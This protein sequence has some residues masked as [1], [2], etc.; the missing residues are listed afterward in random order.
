MDRAGQRGNLEANMPG[1]DDDTDA[2]QTTQATFGPTFRNGPTMANPSAV[3][4][5]TG[6]RLGKEDRFEIIEKIGAGGMGQVFRAVDRHLDRIVAIKLILQNVGRSVDH[7]VAILHREAKVTAKL[8]HENIV[9]IFDM[10]VYHGMPFIVMELL[11]GQ[12]LNMMI[13]RSRMTPLRAVQIM[14]Q[15][16][17][18]LSHAHANGIVHCDLKLSN[19]F[20]L[21]DG[22]AKILDF[23]ISRF[24]RPLV[25]SV[26]LNEAPPTI[27]G[28][29]GTPVFM[30]PEL[31]RGEPQDARTDIWAAGVML[32]Q[33]LTGRLP[34]TVLELQHKFLMKERGRTL[35]PSV[36]LLMPALAEEADRLVATA[37]NEDPQGR[38]QTAREM[39]E[40]LTELE[41]VIVS[42]SSDAQV[43]FSPPQ[44]E[45]RSLTVLACHL[46]GL[47][48]LDIDEI[49]SADQCFYQAAVDAVK[50]AGG[51]IGTPIGGKFFA[52]FGYPAVKEN[53]AQRGVWAA[54]QIVQ[55]MR[56]YGRQ[57]ATCLD[58]R[59]AVHSGIVGLPDQPG[60]EKGIPTMQGNVPNIAV[61]LAEAAPVGSVVMSEATFELT[62]GLFHTQVQASHA[63]REPD[64]N[65]SP[66]YLVLGEVESSSR[67][68]K[69]FSAYLTPFVGRDTE[70]AFLDRLWHD[71]KEGGGQIVVVSGEAGIG[72]SRLVQILK[73]K[74]IKEGNIQ[75]TC[76][77]WSHFKNSALHPLIELIL[78]SMD[79]RREDT[80]EAKVQK[81]E[82]NLNS[83]GFAL[84]ETVPLFGA[85]LS[86]PCEPKYAPL[87]LPPEQQKVKT[88]EALVSMLLRIALNRPALFVIEDMPWVDHSTIECLNELI[89][90]LPSSRI[91]VVLTGR[92]EFRPPWSTC[93]HL[94]KITLER[95]SSA[96]V[97]SIIEQASKE[98]G[99]PPQM[100][101]RIAATSDGV[102]LFVEELTHMVVESWHPIET[103]QV[104]QL[105]VPGTLRD[106]LLTKLD[107]LRGVGKE[108]AQVGSI[109]GR[110]FHYELIRHVSPFDE[111]SLQDGLEM[112][113]DA[114]VLH[115]NGRPPESNYVFKHALI[116]QAAYQSLAKSE[117]Q[118]HHRRAAEVL[119]EVFK[120]IAEFQP[121][122]LAHHHTEAGHPQEAI[123]FWEKAGQ[124]ATQRS[125]LVEAIDHY[126]RAREA[127]KTLPEDLDRDKKELALLLAL[128]AP[129]MSV[130]GYANPEVEKTYARAR[131]LAHVAGA[132][133][134]IFP[135]MQGL[136]QYYFVRGMLP[137]SRE[138]GNQLLEI[139]DHCANPTFLLLAHRSIAS[140]AFL[141]GDFETCRAHAQAGLG[142]YDVREH[143]LLAMR[144]GQDP[145][146]AHGV[147]LAWALWM[148]GYPDQSLTR[149]SE[150][151]ELAKRLNHPMTVAYA[152]CFA[153]LIRNHRGDHADAHELSQTA[154]DITVPNKFALWTAWS[155]MQRGWAM[156]GMKDYEQ[157]IP[158]MKEG[159]EGWKNT[160][161]RVGFTFFPVTLAEMYLHAGQYSEAARLLEDAAPMVGKNDEHFYEPELFRLKGECC[162]SG[163][164]ERDGGAADAS[165]HFARGIEVAR[166]LSAKSWEL[167]LAASRSRLLGI[168]GKTAE[169][170]DALRVTYGW[171]TEG[172]ETADLR[173]ARHQIDVFRGLGETPPD[174]GQCWR[175]N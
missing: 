144:T 98:K 38:F 137:A 112:L 169:A 91:L 116:Q 130:H 56:Q 15:I 139:A 140:S 108:V 105:A 85:L 41:R 136:W 157:G 33:M 119:S 117:R 80:P 111:L 32:Y 30:A 77:C 75:L 52:C 165:A 141:Q 12:S 125:A 34:Y 72:K 44:V 14:T 138:L 109:L 4:P 90:F 155:K 8:N 68:E 94:H 57:D 120:E 60:A 167:R 163:A 166:A 118:R 160:G 20:I 24:Q 92:P 115:S 71:A 18:G 97:L 37:L 162:L 83:L 48:S 113:T 114:G 161:A 59:I 95:L 110:D 143:G 132:Q 25:T 55:A 5:I 86:I 70:L 26:Q 101:E 154:L 104:A 131:E 67:F 66:V 28:F 88:L 171:F 82:S 17:R 158:L 106:L 152:L 129:L 173:T 100:I 81:L 142:I 63:K 69:A 73:D 150:T 99:L 16:A 146:V 47:D 102:P 170:A 58:F 172:F 124:R 65:C 127:L 151:I 45:R 46:G 22:R 79:I 29:V 6:D 78:R 159:L 7:L 175:T 107:R 133:A 27:T 9:A 128:G 13:E 121:E 87:S 76:Q 23:G 164:S 89:D 145:G 35:A 153:A 64:K 10:D 31:W 49:L 126:T 149:V 19:V 36:R 54:L 1:S 62:R 74:V 11:D 61:R 156:A 122:L 21:R 3:S 174:I 103:G 134:D 148:L 96:N 39:L 50:R 84:P 93:R 43:A 135:A 51:C 147:Y 123:A 42:H 2:G 168:R 53:D 40:A